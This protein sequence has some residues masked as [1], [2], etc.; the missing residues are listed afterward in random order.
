MGGRA[1]PHL[2]CPRITRELYLKV[3]DQTFDILTKVFTHVTVPA[4]FP[5]KT[6]F[7]DVD[8]LVAG[9]RDVKVSAKF[10]W[11]TMVKEIK[12]AFDTT[13][14]RQGFFTKDC[15]Y[16]AISCPGREDEFF[17]QIDVKVC[18]NPELFA[19]TEFQLNYASSEKIIGSM[20]KPLGLT[21]NPEGL[22][23]RIEEMED[24]NSAGSMVFLTKEARDVLKIVGLDRRMLD[25]GFA[26]NEELYAYLASSWVFNPA[27]FAERLKDPHYVE[28]LKDRSKAWVYFV[29]IWIS[30]QYP[31]YQLPTQ[32]DDVGDW[33]SIMRI[34]VRESVFTMFPP[35]AEVYYKK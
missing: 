25:G 14:G 20:I 13:H 12:K 17:I 23:V 28:H 24:V 4:E 19:W 27:H 16:F 30:E 1:F 3:R 34:I 15:M 9:P 32:L 33:Y 11:T 18:E 22:W 8:F 26:S 35:A 7:G 6:D 5:S 10:P 31:K 21:I 2:F 29:T